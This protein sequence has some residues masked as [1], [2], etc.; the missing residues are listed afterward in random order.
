MKDLFNLILAAILCAVVF[1]SCDEKSEEEQ[2][3]DALK[4][5]DKMMEEEYTSDL[6]SGNWYLKDSYSEVNGKKTKT[7]EDCEKDD[8]IKFND[9]HTATYNNGKVLCEED[10]ES[11]ESYKWEFRDD[12]FQIAITDK[13]GTLVF[14]Y[15]TINQDNM[16][17]SI[18]KEIDNVKYKITS[19]YSKKE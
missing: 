4:D 2:V 11:E 15:N 5:L 13:S 17:L 3:I 14:D 19:V 16:E 8:F 6:T 18:Y 10:T 12:Y 9:S 1:N 7:I